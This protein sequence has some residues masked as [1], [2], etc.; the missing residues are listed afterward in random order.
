MDEEQIL[1]FIADLPAGFRVVF[2]LFAI[3]GYSHAEIAD[4]LGITEST[5]RSQ[6]ARARKQLQEAILSHHKIE[7]A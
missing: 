3:E 1:R 6:L 7:V 5:S 4:L 2:N